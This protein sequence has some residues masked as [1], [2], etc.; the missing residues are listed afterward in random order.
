MI[1]QLRGLSRPE[2]W[3]GWQFANFFDQ[4]QFQWAI[5]FHKAP[6]DSKF[7]V[8]WKIDVFE[9][10]KNKVRKEL[11]VTSLYKLLLS[12]LFPTHYAH[13]N[14]DFSKSHLKSHFHLLGR[15]GVKK[16]V[17][18]ESHIEEEWRWG[19]GS[20]GLGRGGGGG[21]GVGGGG[22][23]GATEVAVESCRSAVHVGCR[24]LRCAFRWQ[25][26]ACQSYHA[27]NA[28]V[29]QFTKIG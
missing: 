27:V 29:K 13:F 7:Q 19:K 26:A 3:R 15:L 23:G 1:S 4:W 8:R 2:R 16:S 24:I 10:K 20:L 18:G 9:A 25:S 6:L 28:H 17:R 12:L 14:F 21:G 22:G 11:F 5:A